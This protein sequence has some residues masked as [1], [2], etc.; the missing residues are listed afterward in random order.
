[1]I[2]LISRRQSYFTIK[3]N[4]ETY[5]RHGTVVVEHRLDGF[6]DDPVDDPVF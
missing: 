6:V 4:L 5:D 2:F 1:M 3:V